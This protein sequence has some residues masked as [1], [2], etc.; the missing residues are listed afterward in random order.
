MEPN[1]WPWFLNPLLFVC[2]HP[3]IFYGENKQWLLND[4]QHFIDAT[5]HKGFFYEWNESTKQKLGNQFSE[6]TCLFMSRGRKPE[7]AH[8]I[9]IASVTSSGT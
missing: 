5:D 3:K 1:K 7:V 8:V 6:E 2:F 4:I 9:S